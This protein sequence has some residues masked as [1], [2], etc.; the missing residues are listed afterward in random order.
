MIERVETIKQL[1]KRVGISERQVRDLI[2]TKRL[3]HVWIGLRP[4]IPD[5]AFARFLEAN[6]VTP[7]QDETRD[8]TFIGSK[9]EPAGTSSGRS[10]AAAA[11]AALARRTAKKLKSL[12]QNSCSN[13]TE[14][15]GRVI[16]LSSS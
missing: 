13:E 7:C 9:S 10:E 14:E 1:A 15:P 5:G 2:H 16:R 4:H 8:R 6:T 12:S 11:S 3:G